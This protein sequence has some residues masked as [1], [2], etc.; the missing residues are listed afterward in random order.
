LA[1]THF[2]PLDPLGVNGEGRDA[3]RVKDPD[4]TPHTLVLVI[5]VEAI[6]KHPGMV[7]CGGIFSDGEV[8]IRALST[9]I[10]CGPL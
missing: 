9:R 2:G 8:S 6:N 3:W 5:H 7:Y 10:R 4:R 1:A